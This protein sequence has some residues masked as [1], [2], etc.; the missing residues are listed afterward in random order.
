MTQLDLLFHYEVAP[1][2]SAL[3]AFNKIR[4][5]YGVRRLEL[6]ERDKSIRIEF[7]ATRLSAA[8]IQQLLRRADIN[9]AE[10]LPPTSEADQPI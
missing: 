5:V 4:D 9:V 1:S 6:R 7:D 3:L 8:V 2:P 10:S